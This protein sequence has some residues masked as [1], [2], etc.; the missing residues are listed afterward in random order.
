[1]AGVAGGT[2]GASALMAGVRAREEIHEISS[3]RDN[4]GGVLPCPCA[5]FDLA[6]DAS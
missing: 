5:I 2:A 1:V 6:P 3:G 4:L